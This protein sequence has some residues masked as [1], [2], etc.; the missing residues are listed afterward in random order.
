VQTPRPEPAPA[1]TAKPEPAP[2]AVAVELLALVNRDRT[3]NGCAPVTLN[4]SIDQQ[5]QAWS[6]QQAADGYMHHSSGVAGFGTW[7]ENVAYGYDTVA[8]VHAAW[9][10]SPPHR[11]NILNCAYTLFGAGVADGGNVRYWTEQFAR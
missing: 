1:A 11:E 7:G 2:P 3:A 4:Q 8:Q 10:G 5:S 6:Q 9:M